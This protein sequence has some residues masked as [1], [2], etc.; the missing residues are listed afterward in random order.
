VPQ[1]RGKTPPPQSFPYFELCDALR[2]DGCPVCTLLVKHSITALDSLLDEQVT[3]PDVR[4]RLHAAHGLC[5]WHAWMLLRIPAGRSGVA[6]IYATLLGQQLTA[7]QALLTTLPP[8]S[9]WQRLL[10]RRSGTLPFVQRWRKKAPCPLCGQQQRAD[11][12]NYLGT[13]LDALSEAAFVELFQGSFGL[14]L[15]HLTLALEQYRHHPTLPMLVKIQTQK[16]ATLQERLRDLIRTFDYRFA[17]ALPPDAGIAW[18]HAVELLVGQPEV[19]G[20]ERRL[21]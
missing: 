19:F 4:D 17:A 6:I 5:N 20:N 12:R 10:G 1:R 11:E 21:P 16:L 9:L 2:Q 14:C 13:L 3:D 8:A 15:P 18:Q 7:L